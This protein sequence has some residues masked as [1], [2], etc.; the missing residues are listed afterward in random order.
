MEAPGAA[1]LAPSFW[2]WLAEQCWPPSDFPFRVWWR[3][4]QEVTCTGIRCCVDPQ[5]RVQ[6]PWVC[7]SGA[8]R[9]RTQELLAG[10]A[11][12]G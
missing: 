12:G 6:A 5:R 3:S 2:R 1:G 11:A 4:E 8:A 7:G 10:L 9:R